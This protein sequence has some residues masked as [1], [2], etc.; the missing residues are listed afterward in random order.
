MLA[1]VDAG[2][3]RRNGLKLAAKL[4]RRVRL[5]IV[6]VDV[7][8]TTVHVKEDDGGVLGGA[9]RFAGGRLHAEVIGQAQAGHSQKADPQKAPPRDAVTRAVLRSEQFKHGLAPPRTS[10][11]SGVASAPRA[12][13][14]LGALTRPRSPQ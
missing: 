4:Q 10:P 12:L 3:I 11:A 14:V 6:G 8:G 1:D 7:T 9:T 13:T 5:G 2:H